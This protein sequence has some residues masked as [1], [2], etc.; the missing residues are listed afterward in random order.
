MERVQKATSGT[1]TKRAIVSRASRI[2]RRSPHRLLLLSLLGVGLTCGG[3]SAGPVAE[4]R[5]FIAEGPLLEEE[6]PPDLTVA[7]LADQGHNKWSERVL[8]LVK[9][10]GAQAV[11]HQGDFDYEDDPRAWEQ[12]IDQVLGPEFPYF[13]SVG[14]H[15]K[16]RF[17]DRGGYQERL[18]RRLLRLGIPWEGEV[19]VKCVIGWRGLTMVF[20]GPDIIGE[21]HDL[22]IREALARSRSPWRIS[23]WHKNMTSMQLGEKD[24]DTGW[25]V[26]EESRRGGA[27]VATGHEHSYSRTFLMSRYDQPTIAGT[28]DPFQLAV[29][30]PGT[31]EDE[32]RNFA[33]VSGL[34]GKSVRDQ[35]RDGPWWAFR[36]TSNQGA[37]PGALFATFAYRGDPALARFYFKNIDGEIVDEFFV[38]GLD[39]SPREPTSQ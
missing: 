39:P 34:G 30:D 33:F 36:Y 26:Y 10:E 12:Q 2:I 1:G 38:R 13:A 22:F 25:G 24:D 3:P 18:A 15:D 37:K 14:N 16:D 17:Y 5:R 11:I 35:N 20:T 27:I 9:L 21:G 6:M 7:F 8:S 29:D 4:E 19:A 28:E 23:S 31:L 32:G